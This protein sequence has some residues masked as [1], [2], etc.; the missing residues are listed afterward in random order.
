MFMP[1]QSGTIVEQNVVSASSVHTPDNQP[2]LFTIA[3]LSRVWVI[4]DVYENDLPV[5]RL[6]DSAEVRLNAY[7]DQ[8]FHGKLSN[9]GKML[10]PGVRS[11]KVR[12]EL[13]NPGLMRAGMFVTATFQGQRGTMRA[14]VPAGAILHLHDRDWVFLPGRSTTIP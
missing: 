4:C 5:V 11:A 2:S 9:I 13:R 12:I 6:G 8:I 10:D 3:D 14:E 1:P 7:P